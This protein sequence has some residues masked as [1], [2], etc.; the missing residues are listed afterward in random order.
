MAMKYVWSAKTTA[1]TSMITT[2]A[3]VVWLGAVSAMVTKGVLATF[4]GAGV[5]MWIAERVSPRVV[6]Y[7]GT[8]AITIVGVLSVLETL[9]ILTD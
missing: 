4:L 3:I 2:T 1:S 9:G 6:R 5:R 7:A 8:I